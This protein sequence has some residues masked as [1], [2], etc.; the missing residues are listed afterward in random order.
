MARYVVGIL[1]HPLPIGIDPTLI[2]S[3]SDQIQRNSS[4]ATRRSPEER[5]KAQKSS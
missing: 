2:R 1:P 5:E 4:E 3:D